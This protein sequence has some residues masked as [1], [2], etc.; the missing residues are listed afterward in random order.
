MIFLSRN[1]ILHTDLTPDNI[2]LVNGYPTLIDLER[3]FTIELP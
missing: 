1:N 3:C 2:V